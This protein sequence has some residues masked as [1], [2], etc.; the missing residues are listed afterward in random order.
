MHEMTPHVLSS[1]CRHA[2]QKLAMTC[3]DCMTTSC[4]GHLVKN[5]TAMQ[6]RNARCKTHADNSWCTQ[7]AKRC[8]INP[9][10]QLRQNGN[11]PASQN[12]PW[13]CASV[14]IHLICDSPFSCSSTVP[15]S[16]SWTCSSCPSSDPQLPC[17]PSL[18]HPLRIEPSL[19]QEAEQLQG[20]WRRREEE[21]CPEILNCQ[22][23][24]PN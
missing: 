11:T 3:K 2:L 23:C 18:W 12:W 6:Y 13:I 22:E 15:C 19:D 14:P 24:P 4:L 8:T 7:E 1:S 20:F 16:S 21:V 10:Q 5:R 17:A 9:V